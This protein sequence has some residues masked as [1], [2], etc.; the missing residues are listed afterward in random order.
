[1]FIGF[2]IVNFVMMFFYHQPAWIER[3]NAATSAIWNPGSFI[4]NLNEGFGFNTVDVNGYVNPDLPLVDEGYILALGSSFTQARQVWMDQKY[5]SLLNNMYTDKEEI[6]V[7]NMAKDG[8]FYSS[9]IKGF[10]AAIT[11]FPNSAAVIIEFRDS[12]IDYMSLLDSLDQYNYS[13]D[14]SGSVLKK[15]LS[16]KEEFKN[17]IVE[18]FPLLI[19]LKNIR[20]KDVT[21][22]FSSIFHDTTKNA[23]SDELEDASAEEVIYDAD[24]IEAIDNT[25]NLISSEYKGNIILLYHQGID[26]NYDGSITVRK[27]QLQ[28]IFEDLSGKY[29]NIFFLSMEEAYYKAYKDNYIIPYGYWN[30][31]Y[32]S[33]H[34]NQDGY[35]IL[36]DELYNKLQEIGYSYPSR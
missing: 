24:Y 12:S 1:M 9:I 25:L 32:E 31:S 14:A 13:Q 19:Y 4:T 20:F 36:A 27:S 28:D 7:Y 34:M 8:G 29:D 22:D 21:F 30:T 35:K 26:M 11:E 2:L 6:V 5:T 15:S 17:K 3:S 16:T 18:W 23:N 33:G 10:K